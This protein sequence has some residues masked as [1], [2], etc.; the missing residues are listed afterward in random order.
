MLGNKLIKNDNVGYAKI[1]QEEVKHARAKFF[2]S[3]ALL[4]F[5]QP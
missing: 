3:A 1:F 5:D 4:N 2:E